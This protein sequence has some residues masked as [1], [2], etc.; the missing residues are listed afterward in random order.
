MIVILIGV[1]WTHQN[2]TGGD[3]P[4][5]LIQITEAEQE[6]F[7][8]VSKSEQ[9]SKTYLKSKWFSDALK[10]AALKAKNNE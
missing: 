9:R 2:E 3:M 5:V 10:K 8:K 7:T 1:I 4:H 6:L